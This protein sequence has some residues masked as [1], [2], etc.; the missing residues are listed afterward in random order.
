MTSIDQLVEEQTKE[1]IENQFSEFMS[2]FKHGEDAPKAIIQ[3]AKAKLDI[4]KVARLFRHLPE[5]NKW[6]LESGHV[7]IKCPFH[8]D[9]NPSCSL[10]RDINAFKCWSCGTKGDIVTFI[11]LLA[12]TDR[13][14]LQLLQRMLE[15]DKLKKS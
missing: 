4:F 5:V 14:P 6:E 11:Q 15:K 13:V 12:G 2:V 8:D 1:M 9:N 10:W 7:Q 3:N